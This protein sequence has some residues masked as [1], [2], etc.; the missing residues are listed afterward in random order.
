MGEFLKFSKN[1]PYLTT[2]VTEISLCVTAFDG[3][4]L[5]RLL[6]FVQFLWSE[7]ACH[8]AAAQNI[9]LSAVAI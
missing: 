5:H 7:T 3:I 2:H 1:R 8:A 6:L 9:E 4:V